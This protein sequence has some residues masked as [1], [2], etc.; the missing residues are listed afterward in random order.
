[1]RES[2][3]FFANYLTMLSIDLNG[4]W[5]TIGHNI[6]SVMNLILILSCPFDIQGEKKL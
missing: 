3:N 5:C 1:M 4:I 2:K 6:I